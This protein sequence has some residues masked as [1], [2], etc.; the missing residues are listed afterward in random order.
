MSGV[1]PVMVPKGARQ[2]ALRTTRTHSQPAG[3]RSSP[4]WRAA[5]AARCRAIAA[6]TSDIL[7][8]RKAGI[9]SGEVSFRSF[10]E[11]AITVGISAD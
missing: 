4:Q 8:L 1:A 5:R 11:C 7:L 3:D 6:W 2:T 9:S 10:S